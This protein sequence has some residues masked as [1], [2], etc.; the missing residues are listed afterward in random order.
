MK[1]SWDPR[2]RFFRYCTQTVLMNVLLNVQL[3]APLALSADI[4]ADIV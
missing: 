4:K 1:V 3:V 2:T